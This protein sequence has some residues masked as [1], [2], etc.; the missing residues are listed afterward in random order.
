MD[1]NQQVVLNN[2]LEFRCRKIPFQYF[3]R[4]LDRCLKCQLFRQQSFDNEGHSKSGK[5]SF[6]AFT[7]HKSFQ[8]L[9]SEMTEYRKLKKSYNF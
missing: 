1:E 6:V 2:M 3:F 7:D 9:W 5:L 8:L 4:I